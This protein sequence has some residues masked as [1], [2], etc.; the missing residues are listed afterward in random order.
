MFRFE[1][2]LNP[3]V[4]ADL[5]ALPM[6]AQ[7]IMRRK[8][9][10]VIGPEIEQMVAALVAQ[11]PLRGDEWFQ[12]GSDKSRKFYFW[13]LYNEPELS[14]GTHWR[15][16]GSSGI[17]TAWEVHVSDRFQDTQIQITNA[18]RKAKGLSQGEYP[19][20]YVFGDYA[21]AGHI[22]TGWV[23]W[24]EQAQKQLKAH[25]WQRTMELWAESVQEAWVSR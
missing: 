8:I 2:S 18:R 19:T 12:F 15:R 9:V 20:Q 13:M 16:G 1:L 4:L 21:V 11:E 24:A 10:T 7:R 25:L 22:R 6:R 14:D 5:R 3:K 17:E 23:E